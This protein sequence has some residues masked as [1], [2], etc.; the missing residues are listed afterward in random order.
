[1]QEV[2]AGDGSGDDDAEGAEVSGDDGA[3]GSGA[4]DA[5]GADGSGDDGADDSGAGDADGADGSGDDDTP[6]LV[7]PLDAPTVMTHAE[8]ANSVAAPSLRTGPTLALGSG[9]PG[10]SFWAW[11]AL[12]FRSRSSLAPGPGVLLFLVFAS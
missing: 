12:G 11:A 4:D 9:A 3:G 10:G 1:M 8:A 7:E 6:P 2:E 5:D